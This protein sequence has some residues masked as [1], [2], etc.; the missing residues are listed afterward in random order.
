[1]TRGILTTAYATL[2]QQGTVRDIHDLYQS[3]YQEEYFVRLHQPGIWPQTKWVTGTNFCDL[4]LTVDQRTNRVI[5]TAVIDNLV[6]GA[7][8]QAVQNMNLLFDLPE[9]TGL[10]LVPLY[11]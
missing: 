8:G 9:T 11:P 2:N 1:M 10:E 5:I 6:K 7:A 3:Y 4:G